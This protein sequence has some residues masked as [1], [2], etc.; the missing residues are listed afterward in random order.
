MQPGSGEL[1]EPRAA[2]A[3]T[4]TPETKPLSA[5]GTILSLCGLGFLDE[6]KVEDIPAQAKAD[7]SAEKCAKQQNQT[8]DAKTQQTPVRH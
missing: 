1:R 3:R 6:T 7:I 8:L 2:P 5:T 4:R